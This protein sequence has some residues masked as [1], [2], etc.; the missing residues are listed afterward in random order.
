MHTEVRLMIY[1]TKIGNHTLELKIPLILKLIPRFLAIQFEVFPNKIP[2]P[3][4]PKSTP[5]RLNF[6]KNLLMNQF[7]RKSQP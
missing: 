6:I 1:I 2:R 7:F 3:Q 5:E 4:D